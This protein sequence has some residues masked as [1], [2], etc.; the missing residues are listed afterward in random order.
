MIRM[1]VKKRM[2]MD[3]EGYGK[4]AAEYKTDYKLINEQA[5][6]LAGNTSWY[7]SALGNISALI[8]DS[9]E[10]LNWAGFYFVRDDKLILGP[11]QG[12]PACTDIPLKKGVCAAAVLENRV[13]R[14]D[15]VHSFPGH[16]A[17]D[18]A[19]ESDI[20]IP[21]RKNGAVVGV[22]DIDSPVLSRFSEEDEKGLEQIVKVAEEILSHTDEL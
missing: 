7:I 16:I 22:L 19:S 8:Y 1:Y 11:F 14:V 12:K 4:L 15:N 13:K 5:N 3:I 18:S 10:D 2:T 9:L 20:V 17:C 21:V 6:A